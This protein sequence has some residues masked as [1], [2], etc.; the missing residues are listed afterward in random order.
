[1]FNSG[2]ASAAGSATTSLLRHWIAW[3][4]PWTPGVLLWESCRI[5]ADKGWTAPCTTAKEQVARIIIA[6]HG[7]LNQSQQQFIFLTITLEACSSAGFEQSGEAARVTSS[8]QT[9]SDIAQ[10]VSQKYNHFHQ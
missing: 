5:A 7:K 6:L 1:M 8:G 4:D 10:C 3:G 9:F 2:V